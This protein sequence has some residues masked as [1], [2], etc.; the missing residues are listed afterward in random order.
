[1]RDLQ[2]DKLILVL[3]AEPNSKSHSARPEIR[4]MANE[5]LILK[6]RVCPVG[7]S[8]RYQATRTTCCVQYENI[9]ALCILLPSQQ[10]GR[11]MEWIR[12][13]QLSSRTAVVRTNTAVI[14]CADGCLD[15]WASKTSADRLQ[16]S[17]E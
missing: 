4:R 14:S 8:W 1:M 2:A 10:A 3:A 13:I 7:F 17:I 16:L 9:D 15:P 12:E 11:I 6:R 5:V